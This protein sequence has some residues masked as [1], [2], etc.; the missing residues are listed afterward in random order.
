MKKYNITYDS[1]YLLD[2]YNVNASVRV[3]LER[4]LKMA[5]A[6]K[7]TGKVIIERLIKK[8]PSVPQLK[9]HLL[10]L[11]KTLGQGGRAKVINDN[12]V[13]KHP[14]YTYGFFNRVTM[15]LEE[16]DFELAKELLGEAPD[17]ELLFP[18]RTV[19]LN[20]EVEE[21][22]KVVVCYF[23]TIRDFD[24][25]K[26][27]LTELEELN[28]S[29][30]KA[31]LA[32]EMYRLKRQESVFLGQLEDGIQ[33]KATK[34]IP[35]T[36]N[37]GMPTFQNKEIEKLYQF[38]FDFPEV[39][40]NKILSLPRESLIQD[41]ELV[42][43]DAVLRFDYFEEHEGSESIDFVLHAFYLLSELKAE[44]SFPAALQFFSYSSDIVDLYLADLIYESF[45][46][47]LYHIS[48][49][50]LALFDAYMKTPG[51]DGH[52]K[53]FVLEVINLIGN[54]REDLR[55]D[56]GEYYSNWLQFYLNSSEEDNVIDASLIASMLNS[57]IDFRLKEVLPMA[58]E[59]FEKDHV[60]EGICGS[61][62][63]VS[64][65]MENKREDLGDIEIL[66]MVERYKRY[67]SEGYY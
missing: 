5:L 15:A 3:D 50:N 41:L 1:D 16:I 37:M 62:A 42:L 47:T 63:I 7:K 4:T 19:F 23:S 55:K 24:K 20:L 58:K 49:Q 54:K 8:N 46:E 10:A 25:A 32:R 45:R 64:D 59:L 39:V 57:A 48:N 26:L 66:N 12:I 44:E 51:I 30:P 35:T 28:P 14:E 40:I 53:S 34:E 33:V 67:Q 2:L 52:N 31:M 18:E 22:Y 11:C 29:S 56:I 9:N 38:G 60:S 43:E 17:L 6:G 65:M 27:Y 21:F 36:T 13:K 61:Y